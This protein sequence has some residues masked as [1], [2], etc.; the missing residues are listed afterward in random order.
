ME[1]LRPR[2]WNITWKT[3]M[4]IRGNKTPTMLIQ[5]MAEDPKR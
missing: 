5:T 2:A 1:D 4:K 3:E